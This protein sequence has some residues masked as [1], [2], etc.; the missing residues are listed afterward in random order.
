MNDHGI[1][2]YNLLLQ[3]DDK[4]LVWIT[5]TEDKLKESHFFEMS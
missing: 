4:D 1:T 5:N 3:E 2:L